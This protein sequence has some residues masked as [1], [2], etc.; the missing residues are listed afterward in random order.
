MR[1]TPKM[2]EV[3]VLQNP[4]YGRRSP[5][6][7]DDQLTTFIKPKLGRVALHEIARLCRA[8][9]GPNRAPSKSAIHRFWCRLNHKP[10]AFSKP[11]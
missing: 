11:V 5:I 9:F 2:S 3:E 8:E 6:D 4:G 1:K 7:C 10:K